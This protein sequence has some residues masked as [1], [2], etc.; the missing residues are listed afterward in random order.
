MCRRNILT[1]FENFC[2]LVSNLNAGIVNRICV[3]LIYEPIKHNVNLKLPPI[4]NEC[5]RR[6]EK[7]NRTF[8]PHET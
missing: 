8:I 2:W 3:Y 4:Q 7:I 6:T 5:K 1:I